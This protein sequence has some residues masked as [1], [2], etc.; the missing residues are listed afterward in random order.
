MKFQKIRKNLGFTLVEIIFVITIITIL[1]SLLLP[2]MSSVRESARKVKDVSNLGRIAGAWKEYT[3]TRGYG[4]MPLSSELYGT[5]FAMLLSGCGPNFGQGVGA[6][7]VG[8]CILNDANVYVSQ[9]D[10]YAS[11]VKMEN[12]GRLIDDGA[13]YWLQPWQGTN[14]ALSSGSSSEIWSYCVVWGLDPFL[15]LDTTPVAFSR[16]L[17]D[18]GLW[19]ETYGLYGAKGGYVAYADGHVSWIDGDKPVQFLKTDESGYTNNILEALP[20]DVYIT[21]GYNV[22]SSILCSDGGK[23][24]LHM[25]SL[26]N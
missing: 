13:W 18:N 7:R 20:A 2:A 14:N 8:G 26:G 24:I 4:K 11:K 10:K 21:C 25:P 17:K 5:Q 3:I 12:I 9:D 16:G 15:P 6:G 23:L 22:K 1:L 19:D